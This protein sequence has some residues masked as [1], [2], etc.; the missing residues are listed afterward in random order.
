MTVAHQLADTNTFMNT[1]LPLFS[2]DAYKVA[3]M[4]AGTV[5]FGRKELELALHEMPGLLALREQ[6]RDQQPLA[7]ARI[8][9][10]LHMTIQTG[11]LI[12]TQL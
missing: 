10:S 4:T 2:D 1:G 9:G 7:G 12:E 3:D 5:N 6:Y 11:V 8:M